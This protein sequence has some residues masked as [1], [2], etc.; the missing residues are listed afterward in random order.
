M[1]QFMSTF[2]T[3]NVT[4]L[5]CHLLCFQI[6]LYPDGG[7]SIELEDKR[8]F[9]KLLKCLLDTDPKKRITPKEALKHPFITMAHLE[10]E[11]VTSF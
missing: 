5:N 2:M 6:Q 3:L 10:A 9:V 11:R 4:K 8:T 1:V 7:E